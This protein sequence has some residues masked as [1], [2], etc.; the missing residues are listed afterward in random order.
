MSMT[1]VSLEIYETLQLILPF[2]FHINISNWKVVP[3][4]NS[5]E[6]I[7]KIKTRVC[8]YLELSILFLHFFSYGRLFCIVFLWRAPEVENTHSILQEVVVYTIISSLSTIGLSGFWT[9]KSFVNE[10][11]FISSQFLHHVQQKEFT[12][13]QSQSIY[14]LYANSIAISFIAFPLLTCAIPFF[15]NCDP[16]QIVYRKVYQFVKGYHPRETFLVQLASGILYSC[17]VSYGTAYILC[18]LIIVTASFEYFASLSYKLCATKKRRDLDNHRQR[19][20][21]NFNFSGCLKV[22]RELQIVINIF[23]RTMHK[24][25]MVLHY[26]GEL[27]S[28]CCL[29]LVVTQYG[30]VPMF[31]Y[32]MCPIIFSGN[33]MINYVLVYLANTPNANGKRFQRYWK[34]VVAKRTGDRDL[35]SC[36]TLGISIGPLKNISLVSTLIFIDTVCGTTINMVLLDAS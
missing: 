34:S 31:A 4:E 11:S 22:Y 20:A 27:L 14:Q 9:M 30:K 36:P 7:D 16:A 8:K 33:L 19:K 26:V 15:I 13:P 6:S 21:N 1:I 2:K 35:V 12:S 29:F 3:L 25:A 5:A 32:I 10:I 18:V 28:S 17:I 24:F 23:N